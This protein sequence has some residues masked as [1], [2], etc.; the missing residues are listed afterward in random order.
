M[1]LD[2][3]ILVL[4]ILIFSNFITYL[5]HQPPR[6]NMV[7]IGGSNQNLQQL[8]KAKN[9]KAANEET[10]LQLL[11]ISGRM[12]SL[13]AAERLTLQDVKVLFQLLDTAGRLQL[14]ETLALQL[15]RSEISSRR[16][17][18][19]DEIRLLIEPLNDSERNQLKSVV[20]SSQQLNSEE[21]DVLSDLLTKMPAAALLPEAQWSQKH[22]KLL[23]H[24]VSGWKSRSWYLTDGDIQRCSFTDLQEISRLWAKNSM[25]HFSFSK[26]YEIWT[27]VLTSAKGQDFPTRY[28]TF[29]DRVGWRVSNSWI[30][31][32]AINF[33]FPNAQATTTL[34]NGI[35]DGYLPI[36]PL[37]GWWGWAERFQRF[38]D[39]YSIPV[40]S[41]PV[42]SDTQEHPSRDSVFHAEEDGDDRSV[43]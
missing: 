27:D 26:Q 42:P 25:G 1:Q 33:S 36:V 31:Y 13:V 16:G 17:D 28:Q 19:R 2:S 3:P 6:N 29:G 43:G 9:W 41:T 8:L 34:A 18:I 38:M 5:L 22:Q 32:D 14:L 23:E 24:V 37:V 4:A 11:L 12:A 40:L 15:R 21:K 35:P 7:F 39:Q 10:L 30:Q 20:Q